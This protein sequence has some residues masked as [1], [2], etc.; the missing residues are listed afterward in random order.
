MDL[1]LV[2]MIITK[3]IVFFIIRS[4]MQGS[5]IFEGR[6]TI[7]AYLGTVTHDWTLIV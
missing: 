7:N 3:Y 5:Q 1:S 4:N 6:P 2:L